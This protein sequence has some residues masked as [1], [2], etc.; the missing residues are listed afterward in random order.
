MSGE[1]ASPLFTGVNRRKQKPPG[2]SFSEDREIGRWNMEETRKEQRAMKPIRW[3]AAVAVAVVMF[4]AAQA[5]RA[6][7]AAI[8]Y[9]Q[10]T[11]QYGYTYG[12]D[13]LGAAQY[14]AVAN[15]GADDAQVVVWV[16]NGWAA[17]A[18][19]DDGG[20]GYG[21]S[22]NSLDEADNNA[23]DAAGGGSILCWAASG[24]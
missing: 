4:A 8:A 17:L 12:Y 15:A 6:D 18:V 22:T 11:G 1:A 14:D 16:E 13:D 23:I 20:W 9:S 21:W 2:R 3:I 7:Y 24:S 19:N 10:S 5:A